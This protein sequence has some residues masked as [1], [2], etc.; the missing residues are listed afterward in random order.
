MS[1]T[2]QPGDSLPSWGVAS[3]PIE[4]MKLLA[5]LLRDPNPIHWSHDAVR[6]DGL[7]ERVINQGP[8]NL[9]YVTNML[10]QFAGPGCL[11]HLRAR[12]TSNVMEGDEIVAGGV[13]T[14]VVVERGTVVYDCDVWLDIVGGARAV[15]ATVRIEYLK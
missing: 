7:G 3:V 8:I 13:V 9:C 11:R 14:N 1:S 2:L 6:R 12:F 15:E 4:K 10:E 5:A